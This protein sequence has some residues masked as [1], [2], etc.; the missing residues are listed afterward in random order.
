VSIA[1]APSDVGRPDDVLIGCRDGVLP[2]GMLLGYRRSHADVGMDQGALFSVESVQAND[3]G[4]FAPSL[5]GAR[6]TSSDLLW[7]LLAGGGYQ[8]TRPSDM[9]VV[10]R[11]L[12]GIG[13]RHALDLCRCYPSNGGP[14]TLVTTF[15]W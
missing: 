1:S 2:L 14:S 12:L 3:A 9:G 13:A 11:H 6:L 7:V 15:S 10:S 5:T 8:E 4:V